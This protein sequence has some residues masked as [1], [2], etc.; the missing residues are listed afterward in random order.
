MK[1][2]FLVTLLAVWFVGVVGAQSCYVRISDA[3]GFD[4]PQ[5]QLDELESASCLMLD[6]L[7]LSF[8]DSFKVY[9][10]GFYVH[11]EATIGGFPATFHSAIEKAK[12]QSKYYLIFGRQNDNKGI[13]TKFWVALNLPTR[14][15][16]SCMTEL[17]REVYAKRVQKKTIEKYT[18][19]G[20]V[21][22]FYPDAELAGIA[23]LQKIVAEVKEC[24][25]VADRNGVVERSSGCDGC[26]DEVAEQYFQLQSFEKVNINISTAAFANINTA[27]IKDYSFHKII[28]GGQTDY[29]GKIINDEILGLNKWVSLNLLVTSNQ[30]LCVDS[31]SGGNLDA[32]KS[33]DDFN[34]Y[35]NYPSGG[36]IK[37]SDI[38]ITWN[39]KSGSWIKDAGTANT[40][41]NLM[42]CKI[43]RLLG[44]NS[45]NCFEILS[46]PSW[47]ANID[48][49]PEFDF[50]YAAYIRSLNTDVSTT[51]LVAGY[52]DFGGNE[53][54][55]DPDPEIQN[56]IGIVRTSVA[57]TVP[58]TGNLIGISRRT[59]PNIEDIQS[60]TNGDCAGINNECMTCE[61][62]CHGNMAYNLNCPCDPITDEDLKRYMR[63]LMTLFSK[64]PLE[65]IAVSFAERFFNKVSSDH[66]ST[67]LSEHVRN[68][69]NMRN[70][71]KLFGERLNSRL[72]LNGGNIWLGQNV[73]DMQ[74]DRP[75]F[76]GDYNRWQGLTILINDTEK[77][78]VYY[79]GNFG[80]D[81]ATGLWSADFYFEITDHFG[82]DKHDA[83]AY[84]SY[85]SGFPAWWA[86]QHRKGFKPFK[87]KI[88][89]FA[90]IQGKI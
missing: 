68:S 82:L 71:I 13:N 16:F 42:R 3:S 33:R 9:D 62:S 73:I 78:D 18:E 21:F 1:K 24:C 20:S 15:Q 59:P 39:N 72:K 36:G 74:A 7:P 64:D 14:G 6:S 22:L 80:L 34:C 11:S 47:E 17:Q 60:G 75:V 41:I 76:G 61:R 52:K 70:Y 49:A 90:T 43:N 50:I 56:G 46:V 57:F 83:I 84:Q 30:S 63:N 19:K 32:F 8:Q 31:L 85:H 2:S 25:Y 55:A 48:D 86:L 87:T 77:T 44:V 28:L 53:G 54:A 12:T 66:Y 51:D 4:A 37:S 35:I 45:E 38:K 58:T 88:P 81:L 27:K 10:F 79:M 23:E 5:S 29:L 26:S 65:S 89:I 67:D 40:V 69:P